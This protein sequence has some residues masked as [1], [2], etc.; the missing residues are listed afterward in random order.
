MVESNMGSEDMRDTGSGAGAP[1]GRMD[2]AYFTNKRVGGVPSGRARTGSR[3]SKYRLHRPLG[4]TYRPSSLY[5]CHS[6]NITELRFRS[7]LTED[8]ARRIALDG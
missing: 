8:G 6:T 5:R 2:A 7:V 1:N 4:R 3:G